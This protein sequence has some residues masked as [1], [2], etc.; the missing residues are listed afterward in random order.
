MK[1]NFTEGGMEFMEQTQTKPGQGPNCAQQV[2][3]SACPK[4]GLGEEAAQLAAGFGSGLC[5][6]EACGA[7]TG[8]VMAIGYQCASDPALADQSRVRVREF[9]GAFEKEFGAVTC[10]ALLS[11]DISDPI[12]HDKAMED[13]TIAA[14]CPHFIAFSKSYLEEHL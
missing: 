4:L 10:K 12:A 7:V 6:G 2:L 14:H 11:A 5:W 8:A 1:A 3:L 9:I 13:G